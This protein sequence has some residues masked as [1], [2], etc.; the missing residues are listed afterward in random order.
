LD[1]RAY[2]EKVQPLLAGITVPTIMMALSVSEPYALRI[3]GGRCIPHPR[4]WLPLAELTGI[5][6]ASYI[7]VEKY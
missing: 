6:S 7:L 5:E 2:S 4:H 3:R 1:D